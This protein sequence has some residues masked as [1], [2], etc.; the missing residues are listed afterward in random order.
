MS[1]PACEPTAAEESVA[2]GMLTG[3]DFV[4]DRHQVVITDKYVTGGTDGFDTAS[5]GDEDR[6]W[7]I[8]WLSVSAI[9]FNEAGRAKNQPL[10]D[11]RNRV[12]LVGPYR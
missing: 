10:S 12:R 4:P 7:S 9:Q 1:E 3:H 6:R 11:R 5:D 8:R 2:A